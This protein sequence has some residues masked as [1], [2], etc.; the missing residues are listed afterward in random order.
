MFL[1]PCV[2]V[3]VCV[4]LSVCS[5]GSVSWNSDYLQLRG[6]KL[7]IRPPS[8]HR[9]PIDTL[10]WLLLPAFIS[11]LSLLLF[12]LLSRL[13]RLS[14]PPLSLSS[15]THSLFLSAA[16][17]C[18]FSLP[19]KVPKSKMNALCLFFFFFWFF[20]FFFSLLPPIAAH[21]YIKCD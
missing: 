15:F 12:L 13:S 4:R 17:G 14:I 3:C 6:P 10:L 7:R 11:L 18:F 8:V 20:V 16:T 5:L 2:C 21:A 1:T 19:T 9:G